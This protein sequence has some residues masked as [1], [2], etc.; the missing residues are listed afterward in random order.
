MTTPSESA[1]DRLFVNRAVESA[2][3]IGVL[4]LLARDGVIDQLEGLF[5][6]V[7]LAGFV[8]YT[9]RLARREVKAEE[10]EALKHEVER[11]AHIKG[12]SGTWR[13]NLGLL[14]IGVIGL[15]VGADFM[16][17]GAVVTRDG[18]LVGPAGHGQYLHRPL[19]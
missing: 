3:Q 6:I 14:G 15:T 8:Y 12:A 17:R 9:V 2:I 1:D 16:V 4:L 19:D 5:F 7:S 13:K 11:K 10:A 18:K